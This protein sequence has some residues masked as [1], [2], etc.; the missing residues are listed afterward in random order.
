MADQLSRD[1]PI[2]S[3]WELDHNCFKLLDAQFG[4]LKVVLF[5]TPW[6]HKLP[7]VRCPLCSSKGRSHNAFTI[8]WN[9]FSNIYIIPV[10]PSE[11]HSSSAVEAQVIQGSR[12]DSGSIETHLP[13]VSPPSQEITT[14]PPNPQ[15][16]SDSERCSS[17]TFT[18]A[19]RA[20]D[21]LSFLKMAY[22]HLYTPEIAKSHVSVFHKSSITSFKHA[23]KHSSIGYQQTHSQSL[24]QCSSH[25]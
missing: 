4:S 19:L 10:P 9:Q 22:T 24:S 25:F 16:R 15:G 3:E 13:V 21:R 8:D 1:T 7:K 20:M 2:D 6:N 14:P 17:T 12:S 11:R 23:G 5:S 18:I